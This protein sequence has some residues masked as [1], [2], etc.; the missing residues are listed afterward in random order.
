MIQRLR[1]GNLSLFRGGDPWANE[2]IK[3]ALS[4]LMLKNSQRSFENL[5]VFTVQDFKSMFGHF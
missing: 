1:F 2:F 3:L 4:Y 5:A